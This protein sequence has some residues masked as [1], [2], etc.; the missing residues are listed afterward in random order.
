MNKFWCLPKMRFHGRPVKANERTSISCLRKFWKFQQKNLLVFFAKEFKLTN[1]YAI[2]CIIKVENSLFRDFGFENII[3]KANMHTKLEFT[4]ETTLNVKAHILKSCH[5]K[6]S[7]C[8]FPVVLINESQ[9]NKW[10]G[11][12]NKKK[13]FSMHTVQARGKHT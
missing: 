6:I 3:W 4:D 1:M 13:K 9:C 5:L 8:F 10:L 11:L 2:W 12:G 7:Y